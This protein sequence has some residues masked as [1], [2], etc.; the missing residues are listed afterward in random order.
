MNSTV[1]INDLKKVI[2]LQDLPDE[3]LEWIME[4]SDYIE[5]NDGDLIF[6]KGD[7]I[8]YMA[9]IIEG[10]IDYYSNVNGKLVFYFNDFAPIFP[11]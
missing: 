6:K 7:P 1:S 2:A 11:V 8:D 9:M 4:H 10:Q 3:H 5:Y